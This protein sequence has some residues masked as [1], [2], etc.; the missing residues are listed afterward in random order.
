[1][2]W[3]CWTTPHPGVTC[4]IVVVPSSPPSVEK[5]LAFVAFIDNAAIVVT[6]Q[7]RRR[8]MVK[9]FG[10]RLSGQIEE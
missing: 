7:A 5:V 1:M 3:S 10:V 9:R 6:K 4:A 8:S 2:L